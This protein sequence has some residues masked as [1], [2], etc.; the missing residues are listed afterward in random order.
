MKKSLHFMFS[1]ILALILFFPLLYLIS[2]SLFLKSDFM[3]PISRFFPSKLVFSNYI[4]AFR[5]K[6]YSYYLFNSFGTSLFVSIIRLILTITLSFTYSHLKFRGKKLTFILLFSTLFIPNETILFQ[7]YSTIKSL[8]LINTWL[9]I[10]F[11]FF[12]SFSSVILLYSAFTSISRD[13]YDS[14][15][16]D[17]AGDATYIIHLL[18]PLTKGIVLT[19]FLQTFIS[20]FNTYLWPLLVTNKAKARTL[21]VALTMLGFEEEGELGPLFA[22]L[23]IAVIPFVIILVFSKKFILKALSEEIKK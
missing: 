15:R 4:K 10:S 20:I 22:S 16:V 7:N 23:V 2:L 17:G 14:S 8:K 6:N 18:I 12:F 1:L 9:G 21:Q 5:V 13:Y 11:P 19:V 3:S